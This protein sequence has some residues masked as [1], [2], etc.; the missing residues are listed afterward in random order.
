MPID[1]EKLLSG[2]PID[3]LI[4]PRKLFTTL[5]NKAQKYCYLRDV[6]SEV[7]DAWFARRD[8]PDLVVK[9]NTRAGKTVVGLL[10]HQSRLNE[11]KGPVV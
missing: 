7:L 6:Q 1:F 4:E 10:I 8:E 2:D 3:A 11:G 5:P 9:M